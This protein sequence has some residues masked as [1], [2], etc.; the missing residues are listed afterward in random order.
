MKNKTNRNLSHAKQ[1]IK[2]KIAYYKNINNENIIHQSKLAQR[3]SWNETHIIKQEITENAKIEHSSPESRKR[4]IRRQKKGI[5][6]AKSEN[7]NQGE[8]KTIGK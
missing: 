3:M 5:D 8:K 6:R 7:K 1:H 2:I 4:T